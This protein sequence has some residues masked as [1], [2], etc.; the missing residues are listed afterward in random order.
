MVASLKHAFGPKG[1]A[2]LVAKHICTPSAH[3]VAFVLRR[4]VVL[5]VEGLASSCVR[6][7]QQHIC[8]DRYI[9]EFTHSPCTPFG[10]LGLA[11]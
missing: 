2:I 4:W 8:L 6:K 5:R 7:C 10:G 1:W 3:G 9:E 11:V